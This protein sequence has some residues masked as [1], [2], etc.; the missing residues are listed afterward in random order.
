MTSDRRVMQLVR[1]SVVG[2]NRRPTIVLL[3]SAV[4][5][6]AW[7]LVGHYDFWLKNLPAPAGIGFD[8]KLYAAVGSLGSTALLLGIVPLIVVK[9]VLR[10]SLADYGLRLG[11]VPFALICS[12]LTVP[13]IVMIGYSSAQMPEFQSAYPINPPARD[14]STALVLHLM[15]QIFWYAAWEFH[16][17]GFLQHGLGKSFS[18]PLGIG[19][20]TMASAL[21]HFGKPG[22]E[23]FA[24]IL[25]GLLWG[26][27][28]WRTRSLLAG[29]FQHWLLGA[30]LDYFIFRQFS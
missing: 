26:A 15:G 10:D 29:I 25:G 3:T 8:P 14:S 19:V 17:R 12:L 6:T 21:A 11:N 4:C 20:Q 27:L 24:S 2:V 1:E 23:I 9:F 28:A 7:H 30:S 18:M 16:F 5:L 22:A 13:L